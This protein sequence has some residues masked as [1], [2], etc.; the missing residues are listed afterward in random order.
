MPIRRPSASVLRGCFVLALVIIFILAMIPMA[1][2]PEVVSFQDKLHHTAAFAVL[3]LLA[4]A[5]GPP[6]RPRWWSG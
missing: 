6:G 1:V 5:A 3:M 2:V 4:E